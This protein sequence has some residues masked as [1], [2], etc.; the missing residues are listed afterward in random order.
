[1]KKQNK[2]KTRIV[3]FITQCNKFTNTLYQVIKSGL[4][5][6]GKKMFKLSHHR[7]FTF[8]T[9]SSNI[10]QWSLWQWD[11][12]VRTIKI[13]QL[14][15]GGY[16]T[17]MENLIPRSC[18]DHVWFK[19]QSWMK[20][21][22][23]WVSCVEFHVQSL[24]VIRPVPQLVSSSDGSAGIALTWRCAKLAKGGLESKWSEQPWTRK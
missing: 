12:K 10:L 6:T 18:W 24:E 11:C 13:I 20:S 1:M 14:L 4:D 21:A 23:C 7:I 15:W 5:S 22:S 8:P 9:F 16:E 2:N 3:G 17:S 19:S